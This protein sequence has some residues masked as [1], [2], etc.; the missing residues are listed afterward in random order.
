MDPLGTSEDL[1]LNPGSS[2]NIVHHLG[3]SSLQLSNHGSITDSSVMFHPPSSDLD[4]EMLGFYNTDDPH[5]DFHDEILPVSSENMDI[6]S[7]NVSHTFGMMTSSNDISLDPHDSTNISLVPHDTSNVNGFEEA[8][9]YLFEENLDSNPQPI[10]EDGSVKCE[11]CGV[12]GLYN[13]FY[14][15]SKRFCKMECSKKYSAL[16]QKKGTSG[17]NVSL[18][19]ISSRGHK[20]KLQR[21]PM[22]LKK[23]K[24]ETGDD[25][26]MILSNLES[27]LEQVNLSELSNELKEEKS[28][29]YFDDNTVLVEESTSSSWIDQEFNWKDYLALSNDKLASERLFKHIVKAPSLGDAHIGMKVEVINDHS[30]INKESN[31]LYW[32]ASVVGVDTNLMLLRYCGYEDETQDFW[33]DVRSKHL[34]PIGWCFKV[35]RPLLPPPELRTVARD[36]QKFV[37]KQLTGARTFSSEFMDKVKKGHYN[38]FE[39]GSKVEVCDKRNLLSMCVATIV[40]IVGDRLRLRYDGLDDEPSDDYWSHFLSSDIHPVGW[41]QLVG[42]TLSPP[43]GW[44]GSLTEW[45]E[46]LAEDLHDS[47][48]A[49]QECFVPESMGTPP[50]D[51][52]SFEIGMKLEALDPVNPLSLTVACVKKKLQFNYF[53]VGLDSQETSF[54]CHSSCSSIFPVGWAKQHKVF[55]T[56]PKEFAGKLFDWTK[57]LLK[58]ESI[59]APA[60]LFS[61]LKRRIIPFEI[62]TKVEAVDLREPSFICPATIVETHSSLLRVHFDG[63]DSTFDQWINHESLELFPVNWCENN[64]HPLQPPGSLIPDPVLDHLRQ[65]KSS[66]LSQRRSSG[67]G[68]VGRPPGSL[69][70]NPS[71][72][73]SAGKTLSGKG[74]KGGKAG[75]KQGKLKRGSSNMA[76]NVPFEKQRFGNFREMRKGGEVQ[77]AFNQECACGPFLNPEE[78]RKMPDFV[79]G[80]LNGPP[81][82]NCIRKSLH[83]I[84]NAALD[85]NQLL[86]LFSSEFYQS[87]KHKDLKLDNTICLEITGKN[88]KRFLRRVR[89]P[90]RSGILGKYLHRICEMLQCCPHLIVEERFQTGKCQTDCHEI[91]SDGSSMMDSIMR[92]ESFTPV[93][94]H[95]DSILLDDVTKIDDRKE[96]FPGDME[97]LTTSNSIVTSSTTQA[98]LDSPCDPS[99]SSQ[100][101][102]I[103]PLNLLD[104]EFLSSKDPRE[105]SVVEVMD[106]MTAIGCPAHAPSF[107]KQEIDGKALFLLSFDELESLTENK[108]GPIT[109]LKDALQSLKKMWQITTPAVSS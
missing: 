107:Q 30:D 67:H 82:Q 101:R 72:K 63:W 81:H 28:D 5:H 37:F 44:K 66:A 74:A 40:D 58:T 99:S 89:G 106:F 27:S 39:I 54:I 41:S 35:R 69:N 48:D 108:L 78:V 19:A 46:F 64:N 16:F 10:D 29:S 36:W 6:V 45:N 80:Y 50:S 94:L 17:R 60:H 83:A 26:G 92:H 8:E 93:L 11:Y 56:P 51:A 33:F 59:A 49:A 52:G 90:S 86:E 100:D 70:K 4:H 22:R 14:S 77:F 15:K 87:K 24:F 23:Q 57:Y 43:H 84:V 32:I 55:L 53:V 75:A 34:H 65:R 68:R 71:S 18:P 13:T 3:D 73:N 9:R 97:T 88:G 105:W 96:N 20:R 38:K 61:H 21:P 1:G 109:K 91:Y 7:N 102:G 62:G 47:N 31:V 76:T 2:N 103:D 85:P 25:S 104:Q 95:E 79:S 12:V 42:H 98:P